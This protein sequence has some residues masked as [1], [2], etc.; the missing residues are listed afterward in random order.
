MLDEAFPYMPR[1][2]TALNMKSLLLEILRDPAATLMS[3]GNYKRRC[4]GVRPMQTGKMRPGGVPGTL[5]HIL[6]R[7]GI[8]GLFRYRYSAY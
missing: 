6:Q 7:E 8:P 4:S 3:C 1:Q 5:K 2:L